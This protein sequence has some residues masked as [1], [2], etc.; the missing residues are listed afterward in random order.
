MLYTVIGL[1]S[2]SSLDGLDIVFAHLHFNGGKWNYEIR[3][4]ACYPYPKEWAEKLKSAPTL[5]GSDYLLLH[6]EYG[7]Y[8]GQQVNRFIN[9]NDLHFQVQLVSSHGHTV[10]HIPEKQMTAQLGDGAAIAAET[11]INTISDLRSMDLALGGEGAPIVPIGEKLLLGGYSF[12]LNIGG[13][14]NI[15]FHGSAPE[16][17]SSQ[18]NKFIAF[19]TCPANRVL[20]LLASENGKAFDFNGEMASSGA[21]NAALLNA[22]NSQEYYRKPFPKS[23]DNSFGVNTIYPIIKAW[24]DSIKNK[25]C[26]YTEHICIQ[27]RR[28]AEAILKNVSN[29]TAGKQMLICGGGGHNKFLVS[30]LGHQLSEIGVELIIPDETLMDFKEALIMAFIGVLRWREETNVLASVTGARRDSIGGAI[31]MGQEA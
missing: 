19:D 11:G 10:F 28:S 15:S 18:G 4:K 30:R 2:G 21:L 14:A 16:E 22:L 20:N 29:R 1:M 7:H 8:L 6:T 27:V 3:Q 25:L 9:E 5:S 26:T 17:S 13:I 24:D 12:Y 31:W 23:L